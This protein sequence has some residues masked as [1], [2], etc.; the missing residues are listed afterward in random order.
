MYSPTNTHKCIFKA[1]CV[2]AKTFKQTNAAQ[3]HQLFGKILTHIIYSEKWNYP[4]FE[5]SKDFTIH[6]ND[7]YNYFKQFKEQQQ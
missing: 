4:H 6:V 2:N 1:K 5:V 3:T 7:A